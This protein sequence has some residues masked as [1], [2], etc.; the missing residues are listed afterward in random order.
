MSTL[1]CIIIDD[2]QFAIKR[3]QF[4]LSEM[5]EDIEVVGTYKSPVEALQNFV[6]LKPDIVFT[7]IQMPTMTGLELIQTIKNTNIPT[8]P[9]IISAFREPEYLQAAI[10][11]EM[12]D[13][14]IKPVTATQ[15]C[16]AIKRAKVRIANNKH[17]EIMPSL[18]ELFKNEEKISFKTQTGKL[19]EKRMDIMALV[20]DAKQ[21]YLYSKFQAKKT[22]LE[23]LGDIAERIEYGKLK[24]IGRQHIINLNFVY[25]VNKKARTC[26]LRNEDKLIT[27]DLTHIA[28]LSPKKFNFS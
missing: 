9:I 2:E 11:L 18:L 4:L 3:I 27:L 10:R 24:R 5:D 1:K 28:A 8:Q 25:E 16:D 12:V 17:T 15:L 7:D 26:I 13:Y 21:C 23:S 6:L 14:L 22:I 20:S 19:F